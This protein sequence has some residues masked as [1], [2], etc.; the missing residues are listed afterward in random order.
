VKTEFSARPG[1][2]WHWT[3]QSA[4]VLGWVSFGHKDQEREGLAIDEYPNIAAGVVSKA[5]AMQL[6][7]RQM[8]SGT[9]EMHRPYPNRILVVD[10]F[11]FDR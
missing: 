3:S 9:Y 6:C 11:G 5:F 1:Y 8:Y 7:L 4:R 10:L 2:I